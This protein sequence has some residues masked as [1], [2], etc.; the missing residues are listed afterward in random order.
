M[1]PN[2]L[3]TNRSRFCV[4]AL[5]V[6]FLGGPCYSQ[7]GPPNLGPSNMPAEL[8]ATEGSVTGYVRDLAC[9]Y[10]NRSK[11]A[12]HP[13][14]DSCSRSAPKLELLWASSPKTERSTT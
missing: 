3:Q 6:L 8:N 5:T 1:Q 11:E 9:P 10:R 13:P 4:V 14:D 2:C 7:S 12:A